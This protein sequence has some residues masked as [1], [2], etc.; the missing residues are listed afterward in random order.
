MKKG[1]KALTS[2]AADLAAFDDP[3]VL[4]ID[5]LTFIDLAL[6]VDTVLCITDIHFG[7]EESLR[8]KGVLL[9]RFQYDDTVRKMKRIFALCE[10]QNIVFDTI[11]INGDLKHEFGTI[12]S[13][14]WQDVGRFVSFLHEHCDRVVLMKGNH[15]TLTYP[16]A[17]RHKL[18]LVD[19]FVTPT[20][21]A[22]F[23]HGDYIPDT[24][25]F[26]AAERVIIGHEH[27]ALGVRSAV[28]YEK[29]KCFLLGSYG[30]GKEQKE[31]VVLPS[32]NLLTEGTDVLSEKMLSPFLD[33]DQIRK[34][35][36]A[37]AV[38][39]DKLYYFDSLRKM[40]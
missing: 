4:R 23:C 25:A 38:G 15:D 29:Y 19:E 33:V 21:A 32:F 8:Q 22:Y 18:E 14:E 9:A 30:V 5:D 11:L 17:L 24:S 6:Y 13:Q 1:D 10:E 39:T 7:Y 3:L 16:L 31:L 20:G 37:I 28:R 34:R 26:D 27:P 12:T 36:S 40:K 35:F 2:T